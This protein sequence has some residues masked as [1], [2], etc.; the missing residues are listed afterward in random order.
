MASLIRTR[1][2]A[3]RLPERRFTIA[4]LRRALYLWL[5]TRLL[6]AL[7]GGGGVAGRGLVSLTLWAT[8]VVVLLAVF[9]S[10]LEARRRNEHLLLA[11]FGVPETVLAGLCALPALMAETAVWFLTRP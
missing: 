4:L 6:V 2:T 11:N 10:L 7:V 1:F 9:F 5:G 3:V 8:G